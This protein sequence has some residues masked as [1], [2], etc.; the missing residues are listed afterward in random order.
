MNKKEKD[1]IK[2][3]WKYYKQH[4]RH[5]LPWRK[6]VTPYRVLVSETMLQ[7][8]QVDRVVPKFKEWMK[9]FPSIR[10]LASASRRD[11]LYAWQGLGYNNRAL[12]LHELA[13]QV[14]KDFKG[15]LPREREVLESLPGIGVYTSGAVCAFAYNMPVVCI[16]TNIRRIYLHHFMNTKDSVRDKD[17]VP[18]IERTLDVGNVRQWYSAL[19][20]YGS[21]L[22]KNLKNNPNT[23]S[24]HYKKQSSFTGSDRAVRSAILQSVLV[25]PKREQEFIDLVKGDKERLENILSRYEKEGVIIRHRGTIYLA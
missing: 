19:M 10:S 9:L 14:V 4:G 24:L 13:K 2:S 12:R 18:I 1:F 11:V 20:D 6:S 25:Q 17:L 5:G 7:Q 15:A 23:K 16:D 21:W 3:V 8:T 22:G